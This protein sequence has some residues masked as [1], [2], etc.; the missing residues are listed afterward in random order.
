M[1]YVHLSIGEANKDFLAAERRHNYTTPTSF[2]ELIN[3]YKLLLGRE[4]GKIGD[5][6]NRLENGLGIMQAVTEKVDDLKKL[7][8][9]KMVDVGIEKEKTDELIEVV[10]KETE[11]AEKESEAAAIQQKEVEEITAMA[12]AEKQAADKE[13]GE[14]IPAMERATEAVNCLEVKSIT[15]LKALGSPPEAC[16]V[17]AKAV[18]ILK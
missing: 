10:G 15:E 6:I 11:I 2:L 18:L 5:Q 7:L 3:F 1:S 17:V 9:I 8:E 16:V 13:L 12:K 14:A 4:Q